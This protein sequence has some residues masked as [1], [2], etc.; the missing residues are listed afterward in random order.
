M[1]GW[2]IATGA[3][4]G[5]EAACFNLPAGAAVTGYIALGTN[6]GE[7]A[8]NLDE[9]LRRIG[10][11]ARVE[12]TSTVHETEPVGYP[13]QPL[14]LNMVARISTDLPARQLMKEL[15][16]IEQDMGRQRSFRNAPRIIDLDILLYDDVVQ[17]D[18]EVELPHPRM[19]ER[20]FVLKPLVEI[21]P[22]LTD[23]RT[24][25]RYSDMLERLCEK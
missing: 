13:S 14:F 21:A 10:S 5:G 3:S 9:A 17:A 24:G 12:A 18:D 20:A 7:R 4:E 2:R 6:L 1:S 16:A 22:D 23:P 8:R 11:I 25:E 19:G 15:I